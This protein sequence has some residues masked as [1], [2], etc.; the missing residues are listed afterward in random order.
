MPTFCRSHASGVTV[1]VHGFRVPK[2][3]WII[4]ISN[5]QN[6]IDH[7]NCFDVK[8]KNWSNLDM[9]VLVLLDHW[10]LRKFDLFSNSY[11]AWITPII[12]WILCYE[13]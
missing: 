11:M 6:F 10:T 3:F 1:C 5:N 13:Y 2:R 12:F 4:L 9:A 7:D 8:I